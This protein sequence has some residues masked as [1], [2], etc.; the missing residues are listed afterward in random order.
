MVKGL[1]G[2]S[3][4]DKANDRTNDK[5]K[6]PIPKMRTSR[7]STIDADGALQANDDEEIGY[8]EH[9][10][11][12]YGKDRPSW[13]DCPTCGAWHTNSQTWTWKD[14]SV[15]WVQVCERCAPLL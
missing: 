11:G 2:R 8:A 13:Y 7:S 14:V 4:K 9:A 5:K 12:R 10:R 15:G 3:C 1:G 6:K